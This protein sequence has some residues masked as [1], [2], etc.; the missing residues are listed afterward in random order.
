MVLGYGSPRKLTHSP[1]LA[2]LLA[3]SPAS[4]LMPL[5]L[6]PLDSLRLPWPLIAH[7]MCWTWSSGPLHL[8]PLPGIFF[9][10]SPRL[11]LK[12][13]SVL[14]SNVTS[15]KRPA[16]GIL[17]KT[18]SPLSLSIPLL[19]FNFLSSLYH[20]LVD[21]TVYVLFCIP[22]SPTRLLAFWEQG[23]CLVSLCIP[24]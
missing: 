20:S 12:L 4:F 15:S 11:A 5:L 6:T 10:D 8:F 1:W 2:R 18:A 13:A 3:I 22:A 19:C 21:M 14:C 17:S 7:H 16:L 23:L 9:T 24:Q